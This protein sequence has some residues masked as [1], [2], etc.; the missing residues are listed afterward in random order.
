[1]HSP[2]F[3]STLWAGVASALTLSPRS[4]CSTVSFTVSVTAQNG[5]YSGVPDPSNAE[6]IVSYVAAIFTGGYTS[7]VGS[8]T[9]SD[10]FTINGLYCKP[11]LAKSNKLQLLVHGLTYNKDYWVGL[12]FGNLYNWHTFANLHGYATLAVD[13]VGHGSNPQ[14]PDPFNVVQG[15]VHIETLHQIID[16]IRS[17][18]TN[19]LGRTFDR[20]GYVRSS[21]LILM[22]MMMA[23]SILTESQGRSLLRL[24]PRCR[25]RW[26]TSRRH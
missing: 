24:F 1:M 14:R 7:P 25:T 21:T 6:E 17:S 22:M 20:I 13:R 16:Q 9:V 18:T 19:P 5:V 15:P 12:G 4:V 2:I 23:L 11:L 26:P 8:Q 3:V 10:S